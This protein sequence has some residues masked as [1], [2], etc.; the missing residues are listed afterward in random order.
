MYLWS[1]ESST[2]TCQIIQK[3]MSWYVDGCIPQV[4]SLTFRQITNGTPKK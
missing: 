3:R 1:S 2:S 4:R